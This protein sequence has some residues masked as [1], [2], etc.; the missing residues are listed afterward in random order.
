MISGP[1]P[2]VVPVSAT[3]E[4]ARF[5]S[6]T[7]SNPISA[8]NAADHTN[9]DQASSQ[10][11]PLFDLH[12]ELGARIV[13]FAGWEMPLQ[14][15]AG[16]MAEHT[17]C[18]NN[19]ALFDV[20]HMGQLRLRGESAA[21]MLESLV[22]CDVVNLPV[23]KARY[24]FF[25]NA[26]GGILD[27]LIIS[28]AGDHF[29]I[30]VNASMRDQDIAHL[31]EH[32]GDCTLEELTDSALIALQGPKAAQILGQHCEQALSLNFMETLVAP[33]AGVECRISRLGYT[34]E[35]GF[36]ISIPQSNVVTITKLLLQHEDCMP[37][38]LGARDSLR[39][40]AGLSLYGHEITTTTTPVEASLGW[41]IQKRRRTEGGF[42]GADIVLQQFESGTARKL[43]GLR[44]A[45]RVPARQGAQVCNTASDSVGEVT[46]G[47]FGPTVEAPVAIAYVETEYASPGTDVLLSI[48]GKMYPAVVSAMPFVPN[49]YK[50]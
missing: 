29:Y 20:S 49:G 7:P 47:G 36:E 35:D 46:S 12:V 10:R 22:P 3:L 33:I 31:R 44:L 11:T 34:G 1:R 38:G 21:Q 40:E 25:T 41:A 16:I 8:N 30:V 48:R 27:D 32:L 9:A 4:F 43:V 23:G 5:M 19:A 6:T 50:R 2:D 37:A 18:R 15:A 39:L 42:P 45:G 24:S 17:H 28:N 13:D 26:Q 14:Y